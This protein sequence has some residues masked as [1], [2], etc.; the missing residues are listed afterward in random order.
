[1]GRRC[2]WL[3]AFLLAG[4]AQ[5]EPY[6]A[7]AGPITPVYLDLDWK[8]TARDRQVPVRLWYPKEGP[9]PFPVIIFSHGL[10]GN[11]QA[12]AMHSQ[13]W[14]S[15]GYVV[16]NVQHLGSDDAVWRGVADPMAALRR[17]AADPRNLIN[18]PKDVSFAIDQLMALNAA[19]GP[20]RGR[21]DTTHI[22]VSGHSF[23]GYTTLAAAGMTFP[24]GRREVTFG[25]SRITAA[26]AMSAPA[27]GK[28]EDRAD[29]IYGG[30]KIP[31]LHL[32]GT[33]DSS[34]IGETTP[35][36]RRL[37]YHHTKGPNQTLVIYKDADHMVFTG[38]RNE[39][40]ALAPAMAARLAGR[41]QKLDARIHS[42]L[43]QGCTA[44]WDAWLRGDA[45]AKDWLYG[46]GYRT[47]MGQDGTFETK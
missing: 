11:R 15:W 2:W 23:G 43:R 31:V 40:Q 33:K 6:R 14:T 24:F 1:M 26:I 17:A 18:R 37:P 20:L 39:G 5:A 9:G 47:E 3:C 41:D 8:D 36:Q 28:Q 44:F 29:T 21:L 42:L 25:D 32:T 13:H 46:T 35:E 16:C 34:P 22:G 4:C 12:Y 10:G 38:Y 7:E 30:I 45:A 19:E 27:V